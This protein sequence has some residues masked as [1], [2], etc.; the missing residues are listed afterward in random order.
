[1]DEPPAAPA[2]PTLTRASGAP[3]T[4]LN[5]SWSAPNMT[6]KP[7][8]TGY[9]VRYRKSGASGWTSQAFSGTGT[10]TTVTGLDTGTEYE[11]QVRAINDEGES[12]WS[13]SGTGSTRT[14]PAATPTPSGPG[15]SI[16]TPTPTPVSTPTATPTPTP[17][18]SGPGASIVTPTPAPAT[19]T[20]TPTPTP[21]N[22]APK[23]VS[24]NTAFTV[25]ENT[26][27]GASVGTQIAAVD[28]DG[29]A[30]TWSVS[31]AAE[32]TIDAATGQVKVASGADLDYESKRLYTLTV[33]VSDGLNEAGEPDSSADITAT[34]SI[35]V[36]DVDEPPAK[37]DAPSLSPQQHAA[38]E[39]APD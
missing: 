2:A 28:P 33:S 19:P 20:P 6:G 38:Y 29:D 21:A 23:L 13:D 26:A 1:M 7:A 16:V 17:T 34:V 9:D 24:S 4:A 12:G 11:I 30:L 5:A 14:A 36:T 3:T 31:G 32:F 35:T 37:M 25:A 39:P 8:V 18:P 15:A 27:A 22:G 10:L